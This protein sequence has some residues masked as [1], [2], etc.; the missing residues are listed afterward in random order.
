MKVP[1]FTFIHC[2][3]IL[4]MLCGQYGCNPIVLLLVQW[5]INLTHV[6]IHEL[7]EVSTLVWMVGAHGTSHTIQGMSRSKKCA[8]FCPTIHGTSFKWY[9]ASLNVIIL[10]HCLCSGVSTSHMNMSS[11]GCQHTHGWLELMVNHTLSKAEVKVCQFSFI[12]DGPSL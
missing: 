5:Y 6:S 9:V 2:W 11:E 8:S 10:L 1:Q 7:M 3:Y 12:Y 4:W